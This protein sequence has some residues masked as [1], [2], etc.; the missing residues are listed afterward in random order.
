MVIETGKW[1]DMEIEDLFPRNL[2][3]IRIAKGELKYTN[4]WLEVISQ[5]CY[6]VTET[7][8]SMHLRFRRLKYEGSA[9]Y[10]FISYLTLLLGG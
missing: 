8:I 7:K 2:Y 4:S 1:N 6:E 10:F 9:R 5:S 3:L